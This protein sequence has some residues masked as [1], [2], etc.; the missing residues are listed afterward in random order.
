MNLV[1]CILLVA[2]FTLSLLWLKTQNASAPKTWTL[3]TLLG[4]AL[5]LSTLA[6]PLEAPVR[7]LTTTLECW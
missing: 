2:L 4:G 3:M 1:I 6:Q 5:V 7:E